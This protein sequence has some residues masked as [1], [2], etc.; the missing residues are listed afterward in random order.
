MNRSII[1]EN[2]EKEMFLASLLDM[3][4]H[5]SR[6]SHRGSLIFNHYLLDCLNSGGNLPFPNFS[7]QNFMLP[8][9]SWVSQIQQRQE[10]Y[11]LVPLFLQ[12][13]KTI[14]CC[15][16]TTKNVFSIHC[17][18]TSGSKVTINR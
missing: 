15:G 1:L 6:C 3:V 13:L 17:S 18:T 16:G 10:K 12:L 4:D 7:D 11:R 5:V 8:F 14:L 2:D 9:F